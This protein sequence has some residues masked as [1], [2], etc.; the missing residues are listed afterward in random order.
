MA[1]GATSIILTVIGGIFLLFLGI[2]FYNYLKKKDGLPAVAMPWGSWESKSSGD[3]VP[4]PID[5]KV[6]KIIP[7]GEIPVG[8]GSDYGVQFWMYISNWDY[9]FGQEKDIIQ[10]VSP[11][12]PMI[13]SPHITLAANE[14]T[15][16]VKVSYY[17]TSSN[18]GAAAGTNDTSATG[19]VFTCAVENVP[20]QSWFAVSAT[21][22]QRN[23]DV[24]INGRLVK[25]CVLPGVPKPAVGDMI[26]NNNGGFAGSL[27]NVNNYN[28]M[29]VPEDARAFFAKGTNCK[30]PGPTT[31]AVDK[32]SFFI[33]LF[34]YTFR[35]STLSKEGKE[36]SSYTF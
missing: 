7:A 27:C 18:T 17:G 21:V 10:R 23:L 28:T 35:F 9:K 36:L 26:L 30:A 24:Y 33:T 1:S 31:A 5:G 29:L 12:N 8:E 6:K 20:L 13:Q 19:D 3:K 4:E 11:V 25:S 22:F 2:F 15:L 14:N 32:D 16:N 34:G